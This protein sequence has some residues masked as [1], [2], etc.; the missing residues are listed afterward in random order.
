MP[1][2]SVVIPTRD[3]LQ[4]LHQA[5][6][7]VL[8]QEVDLEVVVV[9]E[10]SSDGTSAYLA[11]L[12]DPRVRVLRH[13]TP[14]GL[15]RARNAAIARARGDVIAFLDDDDL[16]FPDKLQGQLDAMAEAGS[17][18]AYGA[19]IIF[20]PGPRLESVMA[21]A[22]PRHA[23]TR[24]P[25]GNVVPAG[26]S[27]VAVTRDALERVGQF[28]LDMPAV[29][30]WDLWIR[31]S[32]LGAP[33]VTGAIVTAY[34]RHGGNMSRKVEL[35]LRSSAALERRTGSLRNGDP[36]DWVDLLNWT[37]SDA[38]RAGD[39]RLARRLAV[40]AIRQ[41]HPGAVK[42]LVRT[43]NPFPRRLPIPEPRPPISLYERFRPPRVVPWPSGV[44]AE[45]HRL[46]AAG[47]ER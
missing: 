35:T 10:A 44:E 46:L 4:M 21:P 45:L 43:G 7:S 20:S 26:A 13:R 24:L 34:R 36:I 17:D 9:D 41:R 33:A 37:F 5:L 25:Y 22:A 16:W 28:A 11:D 12:H 1:V 2:V 15:A 27:N 31:L 42:R 18:W 3:R 23:V 38:L 39:R 14:L 47:S 40:S 30:D 29:E 19:A 8:Q 6:A 32:G